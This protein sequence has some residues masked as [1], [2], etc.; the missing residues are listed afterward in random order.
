VRFLVDLVLWSGAVPL[1]YLLRLETIRAQH[2]PGV[3]TFLLI[4]L[5]VRA[6]MIW[7][8]A[9]HRQAWSMVGARDL[10]HLA[11]AVGLGTVVLFFVALGLSGWAFVP[12]SVP[13]ISGMLALLLLGG[14]RFAARLLHEGAGRRTAGKGRRVLIAGAGEAGTMLAREMHRHPEA[15]LVPVGYL[16][17][18]LPKQRLSVAGLRVWGR[19]GDL[20]QVARRLK[21]DEVLIAIPS[22]PGEVVRRVVDAARAA[23]VGYRIMPA[24]HEILSGRVSIGELREVDLEDL[25]RREPVRLDLDEIAGYLVGRVVLVS[26]AGGSIGSELVRQVLRFG[27]REVI[28]LGHGENSLFALS[29]ELERREPRPPF[30]TVVG[31]VRLRED[32]EPLFRQGRPHVVFHAAAHKHVPLMEENPAAAVRN[33]VAGT[34]NLVELAL[35]HGVERFVNVS[36]DKAVN[37]TSVMGATKR[38]AEYVVQRAAGRAAPGQVFV[39]VRF[40]NVLGSRGSVVPTFRDQIRRREPVTVTHPEMKRYFMTIPEAVQLVLQAGGLGDNGA[41][42]VLDMGEPVRIVDLAEDLIRLSGLEPGVDIPIV[43]T[44]L[45]PGEKLFEEVLTAEEGTVAS[46]HEKIFVARTEPPPAGEFDARLADLLAAADSGD[47]RAIRAASC[48][49][50]P[51]TPQVGGGRWERGTG[52]RRGRQPN[53]RRTSRCGLATSWAAEGASVPRSATGSAGESR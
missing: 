43:F 23:G 21:A 2:V 51:A 6:A 44:G 36:T 9:L 24:L 35:E 1:A 45:R 14:A 7:G 47:A 48:T 42:Y 27:P 53:G 30:R 3:I 22:A 29:R 5:P 41:V 26:G 33:N 50:D 52:G 34:A 32:L 49:M 40:G 25:L 39:S 46:R 18:A 20:P 4:G 17:D 8:F 15:G 16:D 19:L 13:A 10:F 28:L 11:A 31:D 37:P 12:R 38:V